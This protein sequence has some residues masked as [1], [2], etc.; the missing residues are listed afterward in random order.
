MQSAAQLNL[1]SAGEDSSDSDSDSDAN[2]DLVVCGKCKKEF[3]KSVTKINLWCDPCQKQET[4][5]ALSLE[6]NSL[7]QQTNSPLLTVSSDA[8]PNSHKGPSHDPLTTSSSQQSQAQQ[9][10]VHDTHDGNTQQAQFILSPTNTSHTQQDICQN[11]RV[12][13]SVGQ[14]HLVAQGG[15][16][17]SCGST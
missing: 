11:R 1:Q 14:S 12:G 10:T 5:L 7:N 6:A 16:C 2:F 3:K 4:A 8:D 15:R 17:S 9:S 13:I